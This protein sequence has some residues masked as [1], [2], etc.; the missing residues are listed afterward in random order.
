[1]TI[2]DELLI[3]LIKP[4]RLGEVGEGALIIKVVGTTNLK[5]QLEHP[6]DYQT[7]DDAYNRRWS[8]MTPDI[9]V[10][11]PKEGGKQIAIEVENDIQW[12]FGA[13]LR[14]VK[15]Y[16]QKFDTRIIIPEEYKRFA[17]LYKNE[18]FRVYLWK[19]KRKWKC[20]RCKTITLNESRVPPK[21]SSKKCGNKSR[22]EFDLV[23]LE[24]TKIK[25]FPE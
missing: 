22:S 12:D 10:T 18:G 24:D 2:D 19:A 20:Q 3:E 14:Q 13:S 23:G 11:L 6:S 17:P 9:T 4:N 8:V 25:E 15:K 16:Q 21:C 1:M 7:R 5:Y